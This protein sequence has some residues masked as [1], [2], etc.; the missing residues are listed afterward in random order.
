MT[1]RPIHVR[2]RIR[3]HFQRRG[4]AGLV[5]AS[6]ALAGCQPSPPLPP[7]PTTATIPPPAAEQPPA[8][9]RAGW[10]GE[11]AGVGHLLVAPGGQINCPRQI[12]ITGMT[13]S[14]GRARFGDYR[15]RVDANGRVRMVLQQSWITG[16]LADGRFEGTLF[17]PH[18]GCRYRMVLDRIA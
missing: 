10:D 7:A 15:G 12:S 9:A 6:L 5:V 18:P 1:A 14:E 3:G 13:V 11:Y 4:A 8:P 16:R 17:R 2:T